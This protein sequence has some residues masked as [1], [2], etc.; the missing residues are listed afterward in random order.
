LTYAFPILTYAGLE[1]PPHTGRSRI[2]QRR[3]LKRVRGVR[4]MLKQRLRLSLRVESY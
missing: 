4:L 2:Q 1:G 3:S